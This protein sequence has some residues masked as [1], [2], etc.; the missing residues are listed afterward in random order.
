M[1]RL[2]IRFIGT[3]RI[4]TETDTDNIPSR[5]REEIE[6]FYEMIVAMTNE[7]KSMNRQY[8]EDREEFRTF[9]KEYENREKRKE[10]DDT[11][12]REDM[13]LLAQLTNLECD[14]RDVQTGTK[15]IGYKP[16]LKPINATRLFSRK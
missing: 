11:S 3:S 10:S 16:S 9:R 1:S 6:S 7:F 4:G 12:F 14:L 15:T 13:R 8:D 2:I 5:T